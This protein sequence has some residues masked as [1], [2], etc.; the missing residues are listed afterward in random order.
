ME[1]QYGGRRYPYSVVRKRM[2]HII[3]HVRENGTVYVSAPYHA[4]EAIIQAFVENHAAVLA[5]QVQHFEAQHANAP[6]FTDGSRILH[7]GE[8]VTLQ[9]SAKPCQPRLENGILT[10]FARTTDEA[11]YA[12]RQWLIGVCTELYRRINREVS[13]DYRNHGYSVPLA[14]VEIKEMKSRWGSCTAKKG[15]I[16]MNFRLMQYPPGCIYSVFYHE[17]AHFMYQDHSDGFYAVLRGV[18]PEYDRW[19]AYL[20]QKGSAIG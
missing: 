17:Y 20:K 10:L 19:D 16:S 12:H 13:A 3:M 8:P 11:R 18:F 6:D 4:P 2:K 15:R 1:F 14:R 7:L 5:G 9:W